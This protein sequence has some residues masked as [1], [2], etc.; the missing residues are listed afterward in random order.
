MDEVVRVLK[1]IVRIG[2]V[3]AVNLEK[4]MVRVKFEDTNYTS[5]WLRV[6]DTRSFIPGHNTAQ[7]TEYAA[8]GSGFPAYENHKHD[9][10]IDQWMPSVGRKVLTVF[11]PVEDG[12]GFVLGGL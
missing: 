7:R 11:L 3:T 10:V 8:G 2:I 9:L 12:D 1:V 4:Y 6:I 5:D